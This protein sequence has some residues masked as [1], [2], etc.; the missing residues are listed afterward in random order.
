MPYGA[1]IARAGHAGDWRRSATA[2]ARL[3]GIQAPRAV[4]RRKGAQGI[5]AY[6]RRSSD[7]SAL[8]SSG[9]ATSIVGEGSRLASDAVT[10]STPRLSLLCGSRRSVVMVGDAQDARSGG[11]V[12]G[13]L[14]AQIGSRARGAGVSSSRRPGV[15]RREGG[16]AVVFAGW[17]GQQRQARALR[18]RRGRGVEARSS[19]EFAVS[20]WAKLSFLVSKFGWAR[21]MRLLGS[22]ATKKGT[23]TTSGS[24]TS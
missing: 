1:L 2:L 19:G 23:Q 5:L 11:G 4:C 18:R 9:D 22:K 16:C 10:L 20:D 7:G 12:A 24:R 8:V 3:R 21:S 15:M 17:V 14:R 13:L 6:T